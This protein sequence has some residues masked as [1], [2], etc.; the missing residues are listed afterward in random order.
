MGL[1]T[2]SISRIIEPGPAFSIFNPIV[3]NIWPK[4][5]SSPIAINATT[6]AIDSGETKRWRLGIDSATNELPTIAATISQ[7]TVT[8]ASTC[9]SFR[10]SKF[11]AAEA[12][13]P[14][15][16]MTTAMLRGIPSVVFFSFSFLRNQKRGLILVLNPRTQTLKPG[17]RASQNV[18][19]G[20]KMPSQTS[21]KEQWR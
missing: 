2:K 4:Y 14:K 1:K 10:T 11:V 16:P 19:A 18:H 7:N 20:N 3:L 8:I 15:S 6:S 17:H 21:R 12:I 9:F 5:P 13:A